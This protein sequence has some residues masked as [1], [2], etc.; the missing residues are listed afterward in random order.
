MF[1]HHPPICLCRT[2]IEKYGLNR[3]AKGRKAKIIALQVN[4]VCEY[5]VAP[6]QILGRWGQSAKMNPEIPQKV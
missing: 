2:P 4:V 3:R 6:E 1:Y 5:A